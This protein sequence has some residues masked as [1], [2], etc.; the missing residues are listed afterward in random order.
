MGLVE[1]TGSP[2]R[3]QPFPY[4]PDLSPHIRDMTIRVR[5]VSWQ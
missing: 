1:F 3:L 5:S 2:V 4:T